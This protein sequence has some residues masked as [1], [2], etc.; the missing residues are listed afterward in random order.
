MKFNI[1]DEVRIIPEAKFVDGEAVPENAINVK[2]YIKNVEEDGS[3]RVGKAVKGPYLG[4][5]NGSF[6]K[7]M[8]EN[9]A[10]IEPYIIQ[11]AEDNLPIYHSPSKTSGIIR[12]VDIDSLFFVVDERAGFG[13]LQMGAGWIEL[14]KVKSFKK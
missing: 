10:V 1:G 14:S 12:R 11:A 2:L 6:L 13:K 5:I 4:I 9:T 8:L 3:Y 7:S